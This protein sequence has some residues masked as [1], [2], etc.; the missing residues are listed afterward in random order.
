MSGF[1]LK[2]IAVVTMIIDH[3]GDVLFPGR[4]WMRCIGRLAFPIFCFLIVEGF[5]HTRD[6]KR[7]MARLALF[8]VISE[9]PF[10]LALFG[11]F[12]ETSH[13]NVFVTLLLGLMAISVMSIVEVGNIWFNYMI[14]VMIAVP[15]GVIAQL[16]HTDYRWIG[17]ALITVMYLFHD[18]E[19]LKIMSGAL[20]LLPVFS[21]S[22]EYFG[23]LSFLPIHFYNGK[24]GIP[25]EGYGRVLQWACYM[26]YPVHLL[27]LAGIR[28]YW[29][30]Y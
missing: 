9:I 2:V 30:G 29:Y 20:L 12:F 5:L 11:E 28:R 26:I 18:F 27:V 24:R 14:R 16:I 13:Q 22:I 1:L 23:V 3:T 10:D 17:I 8:A 21:N 15:F 19:L 7:Y 4:L 6:L 25:R